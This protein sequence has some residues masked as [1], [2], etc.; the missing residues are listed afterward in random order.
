[1]RLFSAEDRAFA[2]AIARLNYGNPF[3]PERIEAE[4]EALGGAFQEAGAEWNRRF[5]LQPDHPNPTRIQEKVEALATRLRDNWQKSGQPARTDAARFE[6][7]VLYMLFHRYCDRFD[8]AIGDSLDGVN[9]SERIGFFVT[10]R[11]DYEAHLYRP[12]IPRESLLSPEHVFAAFFQIRRAFHH[13][14][15]SLVGGSRPVARLRAAIW[16]SIFTHDMR[17]YRRSLYNRMGD[18]ATLITGPSGTGKELVARAIGLSRYLAFDPQS[19][20]FEEDFAGSFHP[21]NLSALSPTLIESELFGHCRGAFT[22]AVQDRTGWLEACPAGGTVFLDE[23]GEIDES[24]QVKLLRVLQERSFQRLGESTP[25]RF[26]GKLIAATNRN[27]ADELNRGTFRRD[28]YYRLCSDLITTPSLREQIEDEPGELETLV[29]YIA[30]RLIGDET[31]AAG[32]TREALL[33]IE[34]HLG[35]HYPWPGNFRELEQCLRNLLIRRHY[36]PP[37]REAPPGA[38]WM[39]L[40]RAG[41]LT[42]DE[43]LHHYCARVYAEAGNLEEAARRLQLD[44]RTVKSRMKRP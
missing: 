13:I 16:Q 44:R 3:L 19:G 24:I 1:M 26:R 20:R 15:R 28:F 29:G 41:K 34:K 27:L 25:R 5:F 37:E 33:W 9:R 35:R 39:E 18:F 42:A 43:L 22:G 8:K 21:L 11:R 4:R 17:R 36:A 40:A 23:I 2:R 10:F 12:G 14:H 32:F 6:D 7:L 31:D 38:D 30:G